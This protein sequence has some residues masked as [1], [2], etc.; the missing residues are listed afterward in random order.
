MQNLIFQQMNQ[1]AHDQIVREN[2]EQFV[3]WANRNVAGTKPA[4]EE[5]MNEY[6]AINAEIEKVQAEIRAACAAMK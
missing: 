3:A 5:F 6:N 2:H 4:S 1:Q